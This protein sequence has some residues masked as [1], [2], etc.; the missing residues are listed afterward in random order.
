MDLQSTA[1]DKGLR[2][3][4][5]GGF[6]HPPEGGSRDPHPCSRFLLIKILL[7]GQPEGFQFLHR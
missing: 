7:V 3:L 6:K 5:V 2:N 1:L 4:P